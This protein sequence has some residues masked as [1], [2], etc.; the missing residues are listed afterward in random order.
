[1]RK[2][3]KLFLIF[4]AVLSMLV[5]SSVSVLAAEAGTDWYGGTITVEG[6]GA[7]PVNA[8][9]AAQAR[10][11][12]RRAAVVDAYRNLAE[13]VS[14]VNV[15]AE[16]TV[17]N[18][19]T[20]SDV[21]KT[22]VSALVKGARIVSEEVQGDGSYKVVMQIPM[23]GVSSSL[24]SAV[25]TPPAKQEAF[26]APVAG[27]APTTV[28]VTVTVP[29]PAPTPAPAP[30]AKPSDGSSA[31][32][33]PSSAAGMSAVG[34]YTGLVVDC[35]G[36]DLKPVMSPVIRNANGEPIYGFKN[37]NYQKVIANGMAGY[38]SDINAVSRAGS[39]PLV[40]KAA[41]LEN[42]NGYPVLSVADAN[43]VLVENQA[44]GFL[45]NCAVLFVR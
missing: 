42:H 36:L 26:P 24:A 32:P 29:T 5:F 23:Y 40:I 9:S 6:Y 43:R 41:S 20:Q 4:V 28:K 1:M 11:L 8:H 30:A 7:P 22:K 45:N 27:V 13:E 19:E 18:M 14:G 39:N 17:L 2:Q 44:S 15:D 33:V 10:M 25:L 21:V 12:A 37:L 35:R 3:T 38:T 16:T 31:A 34:G